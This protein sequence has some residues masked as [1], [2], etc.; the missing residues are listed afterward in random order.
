MC[1]ATAGALLPRC[2][3]RRTGECYSLSCTCGAQRCVDCNAV[4][5]QWAS[6]SYGIF[7]CLECSGQHRGLGVHLSFVR[8]VSMDSWNDK[9]IRMMQV[10][11]G[12]D[13]VRA[14]VGA[15]L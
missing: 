6:V 15:I 3:S 2:S 13:A 1:V 4:S 14:G 12:V 9:Q 11:S 7:M 8:S 5:P 10:R